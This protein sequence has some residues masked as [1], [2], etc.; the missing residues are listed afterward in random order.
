[1]WWGIDPGDPVRLQGNY[2]NENGI[3]HN[4]GDQNPIIPY[5]GKL[6]THRSNASCGLWHWRG[7]PTP[8]PIL[9][10]QTAQSSVTTPPTNELIGRIEVEVQKIIESGLLRPGYL[11]CRTIHVH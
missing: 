2:G 8:K 7:T 9:T 4:H 5:D 6:F 3:Y 11:Q 1:M 10:I